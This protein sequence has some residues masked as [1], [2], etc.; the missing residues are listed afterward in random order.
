MCVCVC[1]CVSVGSLSS[2]QCMCRIMSFVACLTL[3]YFSTL[4]HKR[5]DLRGKLIEH[6]MYV[7]IFSTT[8]D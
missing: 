1:V 4:P 8:F 3:P 7:L 2:M 6:K 5:D